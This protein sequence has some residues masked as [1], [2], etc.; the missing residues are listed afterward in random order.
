MSHDHA[1]PPAGKSADLGRAFLV[2]IT[3]NVAGG[4]TTALPLTEPALPA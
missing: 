2:G 4:S 1:R 3:L